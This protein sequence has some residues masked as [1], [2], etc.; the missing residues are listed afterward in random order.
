MDEQAKKRFLL[1]FLYISVIGLIVVIASKFL[2]VRMFPFLLS[3]AVAALSQKPAVFLSNKCGIRKPL[4]AVISAAGIYIGMCTFLIF[5]LYRLVI[6][7]VGIIDYLPRLFSKWGELTSNIEEWFQLHL[8]DGYDIS[9]NSVLKNFLSAV[10]EFLTDIIK[11]IV[12]GAPSFLL[13]SIVALVAACYIAKDY[14]GLSKFAKSLCSESF[15]KRSERIKRIVFDSVL[16]IIRGQLILMIITFFELWIGLMI[17]RIK[18][19][20][21]VALIIA[22]VDFLPVLGTGIVIIPWA[23]ISAFSG[24][25]GLALGLAVLYIVLA[26]VR[27]FLEPKIVSKQ[28]GINPL[29]TLF[30]MYLGLKLF[31]GVGLLLFPIILIVTIKYY[32][33]EI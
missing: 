15:L 21:L 31:G 33:E 10:T 6:S 28:I 23:L 8:P 4:C 11:I 29:F 7:S 26:L 3:F 1:N 25:T 24:N 13:S 17:L 14:D 27:N 19:A 18:S 12:T 20:Y 22:F 30:S 16:K 9:L 32:K 5:I 2:F